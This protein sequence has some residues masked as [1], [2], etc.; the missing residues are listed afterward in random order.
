MAD[1]MFNG[2]LR[3]SVAGLHARAQGNLFGRAA[4]QSFQEMFG[5]EYHGSLAMGNVPSNR[6]FLGSKDWGARWRGERIAGASGMSS[7]AR[8]M[9]AYRGLGA[10]KNQ[11][12]LI[13]RSAT[14]G[15]RL[16]GSF[17][18]LAGAARVGGSAFM[19]GLP[20]IFTGMSMLEGASHLL[21]WDDG[22]S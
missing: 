21:G 5:W 20:L 6:G 7:Q 4:T 16:G 1:G 13:F 12:S 2:G 14:K 17:S 3:S 9:N 10:M 18:K 19:A 22:K 15:T 11:S 8:M